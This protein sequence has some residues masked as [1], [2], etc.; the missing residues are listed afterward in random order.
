MMRSRLYQFSG[1]ILTCT[2]ASIVLSNRF[3]GLV[4]GFKIVQEQI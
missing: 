4:E 1:Q 2:P 3:K